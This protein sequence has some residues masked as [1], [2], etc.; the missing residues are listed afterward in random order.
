MKGQKKPKDILIIGVGNI[1]LGDEGVG[2][3]I[4][5]K[6]KN[7]DL[8][9]RVEL[10]DVGV[11]TFSLFPYISGRKKIIIIDA[12]KSGGKAGS[13]YR[14]PADEIERGKGE[15]FSLHQLGIGDILNF[16]Q[17][18][19]VPGEIIV[20]GVEPGKI[21]WGMELSPCIK[22]KIPQIINFVLKEI[23]PA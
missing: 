20:I 8:P 9:D 12:V 14:F 18:E 5:R 2:V 23:P 4:I 17:L 22:E 10:M 3:Y 21:K 11:A 16:F 1:L 7:L 15:F 19:K 13:I 6:L